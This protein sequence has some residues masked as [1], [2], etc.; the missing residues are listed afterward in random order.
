[1]EKRVLC[2]GSYYKKKYFY[3]DE[4]FSRI[5]SDVKKELNV[6]AVSLAEK[7][8]CDIHI[9]FYEDGSTYIECY[10]A[11]GT[12]DYDNIGAKLEVDKI[13]R[14][15]K[16]LFNALSVWYKVVKLNGKGIKL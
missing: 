12:V 11:E 9:G 8:Q 3:N 1:M 15:K 16:D 10:V 13:Q 4:D 7:L 2:A 14:K 5:P 6:I